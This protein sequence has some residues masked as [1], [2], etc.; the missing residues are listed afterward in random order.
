MGLRTTR[1]DADEAERREAEPGAA[2]TAEPPEAQALVRVQRDGSTETRWLVSERREE[3]ATQ[4]KPARGESRDSVALRTAEYLR[5]ELRRDEPE[6]SADKARTAANSEALAPRPWMVRT[7]PT[8]LVD[9]VTDPSLAWTFDAAYFPGRVGVGLFV[10][11]ATHPS[12]WKPVKKEL[13]QQQLLTG[14]SLKLLLLEAEPARLR[15]VLSP[16][17]GVRLLWLNGTQ[18]KPDDRYHGVF[19]ALSAGGQLELFYLLEPWLSLGGSVG[20]AAHMN[21]FWPRPDERL[22]K[23]SEEAF[24]ARR[25][26]VSFDGA[27]LASLLVGFHFQ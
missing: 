23:K 1:L 6:R 25:G 21:L 18:G 12:S 16:H 19:T 5:G 2:L 24:A 14:L 26:Q 9:T 27:L 4:L 17:L 15:L 3:P 11:G 10:T 8:L 13:N 22:K 20:G 7:G